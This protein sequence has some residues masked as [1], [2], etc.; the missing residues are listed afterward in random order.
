MDQQRPI[1]NEKRYQ[2]MKRMYKGSDSDVKL[3]VNIIDNC[4]IDESLLYILALI[5]QKHD[6]S[7]TFSTPL[8]GSKNL[9][10]YL[11]HYPIG[12]AYDLN[13]IVGIWQVY[14]E[15][16]NMDYVLGQKFLAKEYIA[17]PVPE[18]PKKSLTPHIAKKKKV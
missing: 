11:S 15:A 7:K 17:P 12:V 9:F 10:E 1:I 8:S 6:S 16:K 2:R 3:V 4:D 14:C 18:F 13:I 5:P